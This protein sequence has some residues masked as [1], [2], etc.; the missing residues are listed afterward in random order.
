MTLGLSI[1]FLLLAVGFYTLV[2]LWLAKILLKNILHLAEPPDP[3]P[4]PP[5]IGPRS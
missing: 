2:V 5:P 1:A 4:E 3:Q